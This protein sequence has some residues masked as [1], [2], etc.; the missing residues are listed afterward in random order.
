M[1]KWEYICVVLK[2][3]TLDAFCYFVLHRHCRTHWIIR[4]NWEYTPKILWHWHMMKIFYIMKLFAVSRLSISFSPEI[5]NFTNAKTMVSDRKNPF[6]TY[7]IPK[8]IFRQVITSYC[9]AN[10]QPIAQVQQGTV[11]DL[12]ECIKASKEA[13]QVSTHPHIKKTTLVLLKKKTFGGCH[14]S[15]PFFNHP[16]FCPWPNSLLA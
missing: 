5:A 7:T 3:Y 6:H 4:S 9:P 14:L 12:D 1:V 13:W 16:L 11:Q 2:C 10:K 8:I 15:G